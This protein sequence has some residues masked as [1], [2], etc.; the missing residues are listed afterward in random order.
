M[1]KKEIKRNYNMS[2]VGLIQ[3]V[4]TILHSA[5]Q[6]IDEL[7]PFG[8]DYKRIMYVKEL[9]NYFNALESD[10]I[11][12][13]DVKITT[14]E[15]NTLRNTLQKL[16]KDIRIH[17]KIKLGKTS[18]IYKYFELGDL[19]RKNNAELSHASHAMVRS[20]K[21]YENQL[22]LPDLSSKQSSLKEQL[23][24]AVRLFDDLI[25]QQ[26]EAV[27]TRDA[28]TRKRRIEGNKLYK[29]ISIIAEAGR[30]YF[31]NNDAKYNNYVIYGSVPKREGDYRKAKIASGEIIVIE[32][33]LTDEKRI[34]LKNTGDVDLTFELKD[35]AVPIAG[36]ELTDI[37]SIDATIDFDGDS[38]AT[39]LHIANTS[40]G[41]GEV[42]WRVT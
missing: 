5:M 27:Y 8:I 34:E 38:S 1:P 33:N 9:R 39:Y 15:R 3:L 31:S 24:E 30:D 26:K 10:K 35:T 23:I 32:E 2:D 13:A 6:D 19:H 16:L 40:V 4:D 21:K 29:E 25:D 20:I 12:R 18:S 41:I 7:A 22:A 17:A 11:Y 14:Q 42:T 28:A 36:E 37:L